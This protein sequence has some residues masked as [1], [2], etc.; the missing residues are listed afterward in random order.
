MLTLLVVLLSIAG[1]IWIIS[2]AGNS[3]NQGGV[4]SPDGADVTGSPLFSNLLNSD[5]SGDS[6]QHD[7]DT[8]GDSHHSGCDAGGHGGFDGGGHH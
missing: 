1:G 6:P 4:T 3:Q 8:C 2:R 7:P 5:S